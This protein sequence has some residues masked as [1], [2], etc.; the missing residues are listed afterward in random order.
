MTV[1]N[2]T[3]NGLDIVMVMIDETLTA[4]ELSN[5]DV[6]ASLEVVI[7][8]QGKAYL[9]P[10]AD[11]DDFIQIDVMMLTKRAWFM[12]NINKEKS[13]GYNLRNLHFDYESDRI[14]CD[15]ESMDAIPCDPREVNDFDINRL[16][17]IAFTS[18]FNANI[19]NDELKVFF[20]IGFKPTD[21]EDDI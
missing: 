5:N 2:M 17:M 21:E 4:K 3:L 18:A 10:D 7:S 20:S 9:S 6:A 12:L 13:V 8:H 19:M 11:E 16:Q 1:N 14:I 15:P